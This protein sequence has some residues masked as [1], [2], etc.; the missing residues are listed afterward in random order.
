MPFIKAMT[1]VKMTDEQK[2]RMFKEFGKNISIWPGKIEDHLMVRIEDGCD[3]SH[4]GKTGVPMAYVEV[5]MYGD[6]DVDEREAMTQAITEM[7]CRE[8]GAE[9]F[10]VYIRYEVTTQWAVGG[11]N[12]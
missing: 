6:K 4:A 11:H 5:L 2:A 12:L 7:M 9:P 3:M 1:N 8:L 10:K